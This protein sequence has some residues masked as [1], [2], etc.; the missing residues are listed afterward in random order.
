MGAVIAIIIF[1][2]F[3]ISLPA[4][5]SSLNANYWINRPTLAQ[6]LISL[7]IFMG[8]Y[9]EFPPTIALIIYG[10]ALFVVVWLLL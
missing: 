3:L 7:G 5:L 10:G 8:G 9:H 4:Q 6:P 2:P 1:L